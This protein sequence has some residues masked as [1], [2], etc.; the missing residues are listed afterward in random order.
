MLKTPFFAEN[1]K[2]QNVC[3][4]L[5]P[6]I[7]RVHVNRRILYIL[8]SKFALRNSNFVVL[9]VEKPPNFPRRGR[10]LCLR[11]A[12][13][14]CVGLHDI[15]HHFYIMPF[16]PQL[17]FINEL[18]RVVERCM[19]EPKRWAPLFAWD[20]RGAAFEFSKSNIFPFTSVLAHRAASLCNPSG[21]RGAG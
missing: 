6:V 17:K 21:C 4:T 11:C 2:I 7:D 1:S 14:L 8:A 13:T 12:E 16:C 5:K 10:R 18:A 15:R 9:T 19:V 3:T 20:G